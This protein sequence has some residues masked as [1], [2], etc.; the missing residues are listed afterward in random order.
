MLKTEKLL[1]KLESYEQKAYDG[2]FG[3]DWLSEIGEGF[4]FYVEDCVDNKK[5]LS[6]SG[7]VEWIENRASKA[8]FDV[9]R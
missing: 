1:R 9:S 3:S 4:K 2:G 7:F 6:I 5:R 8:G